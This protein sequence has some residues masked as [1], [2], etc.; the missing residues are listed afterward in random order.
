[1]NADV[2]I[3]YEVNTLGI[4]DLF[5]FS[6]QK[7]FKK[8]LMNKLKELTKKYDDF[9]QSMDNI[10]LKELKKI[11]DISDNMENYLISNLE[12]TL[13]KKN[14]GEEEK[15]IL[16][17]YYLVIEKVFNKLEDKVTGFDENIKMLNRKKDFKDSITSLKKKLTI[18]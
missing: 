6:L 7:S 13:M 2:L 15:K 9:Y 11:Y 4:L 18:C 10:P 1:M 14:I 5:N 8:Y 17:N 16:T 12:K 3:D